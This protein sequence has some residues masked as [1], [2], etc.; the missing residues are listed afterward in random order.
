MYQRELRQREA[1]RGLAWPPHHIFAVEGGSGYVTVA[2][3]WQED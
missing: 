3:P 1:A 2:M